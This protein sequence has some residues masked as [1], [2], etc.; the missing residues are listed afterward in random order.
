MTRPTYRSVNVDDL[1]IF[2]REAGN[3]AAPTLLLLHGFPTSSHMFRD[4]IPLLSDR[5]HIVAPDLP[6]FGHTTLP[7]HDK[8]AYTFDNLAKVIGRFTEV[9]EIDRFAL[10]IFD[11]G[12]PTGLRIA[13]ANPERI[14]SII[15]QNGNAYEEGLSDG[16]NPIERYWRDPT[17]ANRQALRELLMPESI[18]WQYTHGVPDTSLV[19]HDGSDL[20]SYYMT[21]P[22]ADEAQLDLFLDYASNVALYPDFQGYFRK[23]RPPLL[24]VWGRNDPFFLPAGAEAYKRDLPEAEVRFLDTGHFAL[25]THASEI[26][27]AI[28]DFLGR[29]RDEQHIDERRSRPRRAAI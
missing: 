14:T 25:E 5:F 29:Q 27:E 20:D 17:D 3:P 16:W 6:G 26:A 2:Y 18:R 15:S 7:S 19:A 9:I 12:A 8:F 22:G 4:L 11:Y 1:D 23:H 13:L 28:G 24:A 21:R 10:Y